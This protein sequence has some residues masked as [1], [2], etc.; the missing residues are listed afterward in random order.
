MKKR[1]RTIKI[2]RRHI[3]FLSLVALAIFIVACGGGD[4]GG[5]SQD[6]I[7]CYPTGTQP[8]PN[9]MPVPSGS[10]TP[11]NFGGYYPGGPNPESVTIHEADS[12]ERACAC[13]KDTY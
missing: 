5:G 12:D 7:G 2:R 11:S 8:D 1:G 9:V 3:F 6:Q 10:L 4:G 13:I